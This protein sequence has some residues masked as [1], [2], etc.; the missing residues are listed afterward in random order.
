MW[1]FSIADE[2][3]ALPIQ[4]KKTLSDDEGQGIDNGNEYQGLYQTN[5]WNIDTW[6]LDDV[7]KESE[8]WDNVFKPTFRVKKSKI[9]SKNER[10]AYDGYTDKYELH[11]KVG[12]F[13]QGSF[14]LF[15]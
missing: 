12:S 6:Q 9:R 5:R 8:E 13:S 3:C 10:D 7:L 14:E 15:I 1:V 11:E 4:R 2:C